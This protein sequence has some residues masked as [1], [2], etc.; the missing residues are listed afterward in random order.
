MAV[1]QNSWQSSQYCLAPSNNYIS[2]FNTLSKFHMQEKFYISKLI[3]SSVSK[4]NTH[5]MNF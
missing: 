4:N 1:N 2:G 3:L 5:E